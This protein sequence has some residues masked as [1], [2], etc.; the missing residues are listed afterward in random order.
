MQSAGLRLQVNY[1]HVPPT[2]WRTL[3]N[4][5]VCSR[6]AF[7]G[8]APFLIV[9]ADQLYDWRLLHKM[10]S[11]HFE[12][13]L[14]AV[15]LVDTQQATLHWA[16]GAHCNVT[17]KESGKCNALVKV[18]RDL[19]LRRIVACGHRLTEYDAVVAGSVYVARPS[20]FAL[21]NDQ[22]RESLYRNTGDA[23]A[24][25]A[26][27][28]TLGYVELGDLT[29]HW[30]GS[31]TVTA[32]LRGMGRGLQL[33]VMGRQGQGWRHV[34]AAARRLMLEQTDDVA[35]SGD[36]AANATAGSAADAAAGAATADGAATSPPARP[37]RARRPWPTS[38]MLRPLL[39]LGE[40]IGSGAYCQVIAAT[41]GAPALPDEM[42]ATE[43]G[44]CAMA[45]DDDDADADH[46]PPPA[47][48]ASAAAASAAAASAAAASAA[49]GS[50]PARRGSGI[51]RRRGS[52]Q[53]VAGRFGAACELAVKV[54]ETGHSADRGAGA[55]MRQVMWEVHVMR[56][57][58]HPH[59]ARLC[60][61]IEFTDAVYVVMERYEGPCLHE[62]IHAQPGAALGE[63]HARRLFCRVLAAVRHAH[64][65]GFIHADVKPANVRLS[66][67]CD[68]ALLVDW[69][70]A[71]SISYQPEEVIS[72]GTPAYASPEQLTGVSPEQAW[73]KAT[74]RGSE[75]GGLGWC[76]VDAR[77]LQLR[78]AS[79][80]PGSHRSAARA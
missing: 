45:C 63:A 30:F 79:L 10:R 49:D 1:V 20:L 70:M 41:L 14:E 2:L 68:A 9:R 5:I 32:V 18:Q 19:E 13:C 38:R 47:A 50:A 66:R 39:E 36:A 57:I 64:A 58:Q 7:P 55:V 43:G 29:C 31:R 6:V 76:A 21:L 71:R 22:S 33:D 28:G 37:H 65:C 11:A 42:P 80:T 61:A 46:P 67:A 51:A 75:L 78:C 26:A 77:L 59:I 72:V 4:S 34:V 40:V 74:V 73:G 25:F 54:Y 56:Q 24:T 69:G 27:R 12:E 48:A 60:D 44:L 23:M 3:A 8:D 16:S 52:L 35:A 15:A 17:C 53:A 62:H